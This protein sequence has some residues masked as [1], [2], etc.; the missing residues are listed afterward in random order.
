MSKIKPGGFPGFVIWVVSFL[1]RVSDAAH[2]PDDCHLYLSWVLHVAFDLLRDV[3][4]KLACAVIRCFFSVDDHP[5]LATGLD[6]VAFFDTVEA[7][8]DIFQFS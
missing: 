3:K 5:Q 7:Q 6:G 8:A 4:T 1:F 2:F